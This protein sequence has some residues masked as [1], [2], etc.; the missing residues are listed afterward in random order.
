M[1]VESRAVSEFVGM[2]SMQKFGGVRVLPLL[3][4]NIRRQHDGE[5]EEEEE[6]EKSTVSEKVNCLAAD[7]AFH[8]QDNG[9]GGKVQTTH[10]KQRDSKN[11]VK[12]GIDQQNGLITNS[13]D[14]AL[15]VA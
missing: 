7:V 15:Q 2:A 12:W 14:G 10:Q 6:K 3:P 8:N 5:E 11:E 9:A 1:C 13:S 4:A